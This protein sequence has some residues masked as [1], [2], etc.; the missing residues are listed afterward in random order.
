MNL[1]LARR[2]ENLF[3][4]CNC[5]LAIA[6]PSLAL[7]LAVHGLMEKPALLSKESLGLVR[8]PCR[9]Q[10]TKEISFPML[11]PC[12]ETKFLEDRPVETEKPPPETPRPVL[13]LV[14]LPF[15]WVGVAVHPVAKNSAVILLDKRSQKQILVQG[16][17]FIR[18]S[19]YKIIHITEDEVKIQLGEAVST[20]TKPKPWQFIHKPEEDPMAASFDTQITVDDNNVIVAVENEALLGNGLREQD[21]VIAVE[22]KAVA[23]L[24]EFKATLSTVSKDFLA[25][26]IRRQEERITFLLPTQVIRQI[27]QVPPSR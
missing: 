27:L 22:G 23:N 21:Q 19:K 9:I 3:L 1:R 5:L 4:L 20:L 13:T 15:E 16:G 26:L 6:V 18:G 7:K 25:L 2:L 11:A 24:T 17:K 10:E 8:P 12:Y 14:E